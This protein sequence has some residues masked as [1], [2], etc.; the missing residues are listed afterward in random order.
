MI[1]KFVLRVT[2]WEDPLQNP[3][4]ATAVMVMKTGRVSNNGSSKILGR[5]S[6][7]EKHKPF[8]PKYVSIDVHTQLDPGIDMSCVPPGHT[9]QPVGVSMCVFVCWTTCGLVVV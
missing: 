8:V 5:I 2:I 9:I 1:N 7:P 6:L 3:G 4:S